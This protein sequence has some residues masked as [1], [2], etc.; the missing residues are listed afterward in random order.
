VLFLILKG[1]LKYLYKMSSPFFL[2]FIVIIHS[3]C[4]FRLLVFIVTYYLS[5]LILSFKLS[6]WLFLRIHQH[7]VFSCVLK[8]SLWIQISYSNY[9]T[10]TAISRLVVYLIVLIFLPII[11]SF[12]LKGLILK[13]IV[14][15]CLLSY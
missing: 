14:L 11:I 9:S 13:M 5:S 2:F 1:F 3:L 15:R 8:I 10:F 6:F 12:N 4:Q 7:L